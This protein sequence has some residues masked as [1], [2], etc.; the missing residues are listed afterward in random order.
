VKY[1]VKLRGASSAAI[2]PGKAEKITKIARI[3]IPS[4]IIGS[5]L[6]KPLHA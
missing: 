1:G 2:L 6:I 5:A 3:L 4:A